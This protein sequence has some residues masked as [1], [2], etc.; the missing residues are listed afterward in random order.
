MEDDAGWV[1]QDKR[2][3]KKPKST[4]QP[5]PATADDQ[6]SKAFVFSIEILVFY[7]FLPFGFGVSKMLFAF[8]TFFGQCLQLSSFQHASNAY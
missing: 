6:K 7:G 5:P 1:T 2:K 3:N 8:Q 4:P